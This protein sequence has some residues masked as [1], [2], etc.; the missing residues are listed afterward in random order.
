MTALE[1]SAVLRSAPAL[2]F[3]GANASA[4]KPGETDCNSP[5]HWDGRTLY[6]FNSAGEPWRSAGP[7]LLHLTSNYVRCEF[8]T[9]PLGGRWI[10]ATWKEP[11]SFLYGWYHLEPAGLCPGRTLTAP[12]I[13]AARSLDNGKTWQDLG[14]IIDTPTNTFRCDSPNKYFAGGHGDF[15]VMADPRRDYIYF[16]FSNY[17]GPL[18]E[19]G[20]C[21]ARM[22]FSDLDGPAG[23]VW[24]WDGTVWS[25]PG[26]GGPATAIFP[27]K[28]DWHRFDADAFWGPSIHYNSHLGQYVMLLNHAID[29]DWKQEGVYVSFINSLENPAKWTQPKKILG[30]LR[31]DEWYPQVAGLN[32][33]E[34]DKV[35]G[36]MSRLFVRG[37]S[38]WEILFL[39]PSEQIPARAQ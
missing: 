29:S 33:G 1:P 13:G 26:L 3:P 32:K 30:D 38:R 16:F 36:Q 20:V 28:I 21:V 18:S 31:K 9:K 14:I 23:K 12:R 17:T 10:E 35:V 19:Q 11:G 5:M 22:R 27:A 15:S 8:D 39:K 2:R 6:L 37:E 24:K 34:T 7:D 25:G 4:A